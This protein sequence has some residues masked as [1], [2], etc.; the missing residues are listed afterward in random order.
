MADEGFSGAFRSMYINEDMLTYLQDMVGDKQ[1]NRRG[2]P[3][4]WCRVWL[5]NGLVEYGN[6]PKHLPG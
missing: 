6:S 1:Y 3:M 2:E 4:Y 5:H